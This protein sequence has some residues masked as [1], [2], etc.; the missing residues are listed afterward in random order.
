MFQAMIRCPSTG[1]LVP[2]GLTFGTLSAFDATTLIN[3]VV[4]CAYCGGRH[5]V[6]NSTVKVVPNELS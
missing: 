4:Q 1:K 5:V 3:N 6:D 2:T